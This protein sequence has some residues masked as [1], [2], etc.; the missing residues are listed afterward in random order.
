MT[1]TI[2]PYI[3][4]LVSRRNGLEPVSFSDRINALFRNGLDESQDPLSQLLEIIAS[5]EEH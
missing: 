4:E 3:V 5:G 2:H 1:Q